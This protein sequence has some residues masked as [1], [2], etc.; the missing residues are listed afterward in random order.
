MKLFV[1]MA[2]MCGG[3]ASTAPRPIQVNRPRIASA[4]IQAF[5]SPSTRN[6][7]I[8]GYLRPTP[9][10][11]QLEAV[12]LPGVGGADRQAHGKRARVTEVSGRNRRP[13]GKRQSKARGENY[14]VGPAGRAAAAA[15]DKAVANV[16]RR[17]QT[18]Q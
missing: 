18:R 10:L 6:V 9:P 11:G 15:K 8:P 5:C 2:N 3:E 14:D 17:L 16:G 7:T 13:R 4:A 12:I 1:P